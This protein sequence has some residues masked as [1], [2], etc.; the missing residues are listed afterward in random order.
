MWH[1]PADQLAELADRSPTAAELEHLRTCDEC[2]REHAAHER[3]H[4]LA[5]AARDEVRASPPL[6]QWDTLA[7]SL[8]DEGLV[9]DQSAVRGTIRP[10]WQRPWTQAA[11]AALIAAA[12][13]AIGRDSAGAPLLGTTTESATT[14]AGAAAATAQGADTM[15]PAF[16]SVEEAAAVLT[17][18]ER[19]YAQA[20]AYL[21]Q[22]DTASGHD[23]ETYRTR[24]AALDDVMA[25]TREALHDAPADPVINRYYLATLGAREAT[26]RQLRTTTY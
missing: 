18:A 14:S 25:T 16:R 2:A 9:R 8:R 12:G 24:L 21:V 7:S 17:R 26:L 6:S 20:A 4:S 3:L 19:E 1:L 5:R 11:A 23:S 15:M 22:R 10:A 13:I